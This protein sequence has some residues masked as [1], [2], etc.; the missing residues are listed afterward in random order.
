MTEKRKSPIRRQFNVKTLTKAVKAIHAAP[1]F[2]KIYLVED[3]LDQLLRWAETVE[4]KLRKLK[5]Q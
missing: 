1:R 2:E 5:K 4:R 3:A